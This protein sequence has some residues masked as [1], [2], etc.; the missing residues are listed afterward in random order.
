MSLFI[1][2][3]TFFSTILLAD[4]PFLHDHVIRLSSRDLFEGSG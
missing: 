3:K 1:T 2:D 4:T